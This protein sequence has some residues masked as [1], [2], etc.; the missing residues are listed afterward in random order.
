MFY[1]RGD[2]TS[3]ELYELNSVIQSPNIAIWIMRKLYN[4]IPIQVIIKLVSEYLRYYGNSST[5]EQAN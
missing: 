5:G 1:I 3:H 2:V 4:A